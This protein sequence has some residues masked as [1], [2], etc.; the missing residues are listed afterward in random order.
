MS[1]GSLLRWQSFARPSPVPP[2][3]SAQ[4]AFPFQQPQSWLSPRLARMKGIS[5]P[6]PPKSHP[7]LLQRKAE[8][9]QGKGK[10]TLSIAC[11]LSPPSCVCFHTG[12]LEGH[13]VAPT[14]LHGELHASPGGSPR[15]GVGLGGQGW[16]HRAPGADTPAYFPLTSQPS[17]GKAARRPQAPSRR[18]EGQVISSTAAPGTHSA[19]FKYTG[20][21]RK[22]IL[23]LPCFLPAAC[24]HPYTHPAL[25]IKHLCPAQPSHAMPA[26]GKSYLIPTA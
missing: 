15:A 4:K 12:G 20:R 1:Q 25:C 14:Q 26:R 9:D 6:P 7:F 10:A 17:P 19:F 3:D 21:G 11:H 2:K 5:V 16:P 13:I 23:S 8:D 22:I 24:T 18:K